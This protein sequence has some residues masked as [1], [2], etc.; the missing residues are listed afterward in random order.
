MK[1]LITGGHGFIGRYARAALPKT[2]EIL[3]PARNELDLSDHKALSA[4]ISH[5]RPTHLLHLAWYVEHGAFWNSP[6]NFDWVCHTLHLLKTFH[7][8][9][10]KRAVCA[11]TC[12]EYEAVSTPMKEDETP[13]N[14]ASVYGACKAATGNL[15][16]AYAQMA[17][18]S[19]GWGRIFLPYGPGEPSGKLIPSLIRVLQGHAAPFGI[20]KA[21]RRDFIHGKDTGAALAALLRSEESGIYNIGSS[22][23]VSL[24][25]LTE[26]LA[27]LLK[28]DPAPI[29][30]QLPS[31]P[32]PITCIEADTTKL[33]ALGWKPA[34]T[35]EAGLQDYIE[36]I[37]AA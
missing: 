20:N 10:G 27:R 35:L 24:Q 14:P 1:I 37:N 30:Q 2:A 16:R 12:F 15:V 9:G 33:K 31:K 36:R 22:H 26:A 25:E 32:D 6:A 28:A 3:A 13:L 21:V 34:I 19:W 11:G 18:L 23:A 17:G 5:H 4:H 8:A 7:E 29:L